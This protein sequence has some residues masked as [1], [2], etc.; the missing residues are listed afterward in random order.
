MRETPCRA[1]GGGQSR[2]SGTAPR[3]A[4]FPPALSYPCH[5]RHPRSNPPP[6]GA[7]VSSPWH[8]LATQNFLGRDVPAPIP[9]HNYFGGGDVSSPHLPRLRNQHPLGRDVPAPI[10][11]HNY[12]GGGDVSSPHLP[13]LRNQH[14][15][16][17]DVPAPIQ[18]LN[19]LAACHQFG[20]SPALTQPVF[21]TLKG[22]QTVAGGKAARP[23]PPVPRPQNSSPL[24]LRRG[25]GVAAPR[26]FS[27]P[28]VPIHRDAPRYHGV[29]RKL[30]Q[31]A[32]LWRTE[33]VRA[34]APP[35][36]ASVCVVCGPVLPTAKPE[37]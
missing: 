3:L 6:R 20:T 32:S 37:G 10:P 8:P 11:T 1:P 24:R 25:L 15:L 28:S 29:A 13:R 23:P 26:S 2:S 36:S 17:Q 33:S 4:P 9:T 35:I 14:P 22:F 18:T 19:Y 31:G 34:E 7:D 5:P 30:I 27:K 16:G 21:K 12:F